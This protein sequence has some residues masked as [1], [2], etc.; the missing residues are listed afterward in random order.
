MIELVLKLRH[1]GSV[2]MI[3]I[4]TQISPVSEREY[5]ALGIYY[6]HYQ[7]RYDKSRDQRV[8][9]SEPGFF[10]VFC[11]RLYITTFKINFVP[12]TQ[13]E[14]FRGVFRGA[15][16]SKITSRKNSVIY[17]RLFTDCSQI[18]RNQFTE[19]IFCVHLYFL[20]YNHR[21]KNLPI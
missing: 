18:R 8:G 4:R 14:V 9:S 2:L 7:Y 11:H 3:Q 20:Y 5:A 16:Y 15:A 17:S 10:S 12:D 13:P 21:K 1:K 6:D 19:T